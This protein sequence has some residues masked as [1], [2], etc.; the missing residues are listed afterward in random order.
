MEALTTARRLRPWAVGNI[1]Y[2]ILIVEDEDDAAETLVSHIER[3][4]REKNL[5]FHTTRSK[6]ADQVVKASRQFDL[7][8]MDI[9]LPGMNGMDAAELL[10][11]YDQET[12]IVFVTN[13]A[14]YAVRGYEVDALDFMVKPVGYYHF[15]MR[16]DKAMRAVER[17]HAQS[18]TLSTRGGLYVLPVSDIVYI[19][20]VNH[21]IVYHVS[22]TSGVIGPDDEP[23]RVRGSLSKVEEELPA[24]QFLRISSGCLVNMAHVRSMNA[25]ELVMSDGTKLYASRA[26]RREVLE[27]LTDYLGGSI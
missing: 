8:F 15:S 13:L 1:M 23:P 17:R 12:P 10:R 20:V 14:Q 25:G 11:V 22:S 4:G 9:D 2:E 6:T 3:Y 5:E 18:I 21:D 26:R 24:G 16:M 19:D 7:V 27:T